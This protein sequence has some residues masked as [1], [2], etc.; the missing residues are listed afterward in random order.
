MTDLQDNIPQQNSNQSKSRTSKLVITVMALIVMIPIVWVGISFLSW[1]NISVH[2]MWCWEHFK[3]LHLALIL[4][5][6]GNKDPLPLPENWCDIVHTQDDI[7]L[8][9]LNCVDSDT[10]EGESAYAMNVNA[11]GRK[12]NELPDDMV[13]LFESDKG[14]E[15]TRSLPFAERVFVKLRNT[16]EFDKGKDSYVVYPLRWNQLGESGDAAFRHFVGKEKCC[17]VLFAN[18]DIQLVSKVDFPN[19]HWTADKP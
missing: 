16:Q 11:S 9:T 13:L 18:G 8:K 12:L 5:S 4:Y 19:L 7:P 6:H 10:V 1:L 2:N 15:Q 17:H 14:K 3:N